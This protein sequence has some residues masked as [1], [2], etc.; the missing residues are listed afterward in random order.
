MSNNRKS[1]NSVTPG[2]DSKYTFKS[3]NNTN[4]QNI[5]INI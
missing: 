5:F 4:Y 1:L 3:N 2:D